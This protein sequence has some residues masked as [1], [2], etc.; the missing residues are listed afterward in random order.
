[1][2]KTLN[3]Q[4]KDCPLFESISI[5]EVENEVIDLHNDYEFNNLVLDNNCKKIILSFLNISNIKIS[6]IL[7]FE[8]IEIKS[9]NIKQFVIHD[10]ITLDNLYR[11]KTE[12]EGMLIEVNND[13]L[14]YMYL[15]FLEDIQI[16]FWSSNLICLLTQG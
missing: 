3:I 1:M 5:L 11:G 14:S 8:K 2:K 15:D 6:V 7:T 4:L 9:L 12:N 13:N 16:E 10:K